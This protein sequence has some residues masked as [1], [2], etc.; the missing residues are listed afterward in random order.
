MPVVP[1]LRNRIV[2]RASV[3]LAF[4]LAVIPGFG[5]GHSGEETAAKLIV[6]EPR[7]RIWAT[8][9]DGSIIKPLQCSSEPQLE[10]EQE[11]A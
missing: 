6:A 5:C 9:S 10:L 1:S 7:L 11:L 2:I 3:A 4:A 8:D